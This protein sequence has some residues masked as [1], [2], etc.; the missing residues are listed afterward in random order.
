MVELEVF[1]SPDLSEQTTCV[2]TCSSFTPVA[3]SGNVPV[4]TT[5]GGGGVPIPLVVGIAA[6]ACC[7][8]VVAVCAYQGVNG[9]KALRKR[10]LGKSP[11]SEGSGS[12]DEE[13]EESVF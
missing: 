11:R 12:P 2:G 5:Q 8:A 4:D 1:S 6:L 13:E 7:C 10:G 3:E 9:P